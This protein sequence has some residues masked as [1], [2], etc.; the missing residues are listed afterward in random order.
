MKKFKFS[1]EQLLKYRTDLAEHVKLSLSGKTG[2]I[3]SLKNDIEDSYTKQKANFVESRINF[4]I[5]NLRQSEH[6]SVYQENK[7]VV[8]SK[9]IHRLEVERRELLKLYQER[10][11]EQLVLEH[12]KQRAQKKYKRSVLQKEQINLD[13]MINSFLH[14][15]EERY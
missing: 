4:D 8:A 2:V 15:D 7:R 13:D 1:L 12:I 10:L 6:Y 5:H 11:K 9:K 3:N 14:A